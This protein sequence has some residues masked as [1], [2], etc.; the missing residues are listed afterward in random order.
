MRT[1]AF[2]LLAAGSLLPVAG[3]AVMHLHLTDSSPKADARLAE[4]PHELVLTF[5]ARPEAALSRVRVMRSDSVAVETGKLEAASDTLS[6][7]ADFTSPLEAGA[8]VVSWRAAGKDGHAV[9]GRYM[10][11]VTAG[12]ATDASARPA[13]SR[14][15]SSH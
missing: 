15:H 2:S 14:D 10:F 1:S 5:S 12:A 4:A 7:R 13:I 11:T 9:S 3:I 6:L 8:Y